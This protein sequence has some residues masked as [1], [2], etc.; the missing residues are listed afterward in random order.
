MKKHSLRKNDPPPAAGSAQKNIFQQLAAV[1]HAFWTVLFIAAPMLFVLYFAF[2]D[3]DGSFS[4]SNITDLGQYTN[5]FIL[6]IAFALIATAVCLIIGYPL[7]YFMSRQSQRAQKVLMVL[8]MLPMWCN[9][10]IR[11]YALMALLDNGGL[12]NSLLKN[13]GLEPLPIVGSYFGVILGMVYDFLP[14]MVL[15]IFTAMTKLDYR[16][17]EAS[18]DL[19]CN[20]LQTMTRV[21]MPLTLS[22]VVSG[23]TMVFVP[24]IS[25]F[26]ISQKLGAGK[27]D[28]VGDTIERLFQN[29]STYNVGAAMSL[30]MMILIL[31]S[32]TIMNK[33][34]DEE[35]GMVP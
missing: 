33:F 5:V 26:Y 21:V 34:S 3:A 11:T 13:L 4:F 9:L 27:I 17:I 6:S 1:P 15:P 31:I 12:L 22:G 32:L 28:L 2:T 23:V 14:Y 16:Y 18:H 25:T 35:G 30:V 20:G 8:I 29:V 24:S 10:L 19:G 7:A